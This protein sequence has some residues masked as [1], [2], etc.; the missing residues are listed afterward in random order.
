[1]LELNKLNE[2]ERSFR[3]QNSINVLELNKLNEQE[4]SFRKQKSNMKGGFNGIPLV[5]K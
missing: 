3:K 4:R 1:M 5:S 2:Q